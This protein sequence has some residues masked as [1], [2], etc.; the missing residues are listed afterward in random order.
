M[1]GQRIS[2]FSLI[3]LVVVLT[4]FS[5]MIAMGAPLL[6]EWQAN[7]KVRS[8]AEA[9]QNDLRQAQGEAVRRNRQVAF[10]L[11]NDAP[12]PDPTTNILP[13][14]APSNPANNWVL[15]ALPL[16]DSTE[17]K[18]EAS[19]SA[20][21][22]LSHVQ[23]SNTTTTIT[24]GVSILCFNSVGRLVYSVTTTIENAGGEKCGVLPATAAPIEFQ[25]QNARADRPLRVQVRVG[26]Q[27]RMCD[28]GRS[29][30]TQPDG[31]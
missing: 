13:V 22:I 6:A 10:V 30:A 24:G 11:T 1:L 4:I 15:L 31:C 25:I 23:S 20:G 8:V 26:G 7:G 29:I 2:G 18:D 16:R 28:P 19:R 5:I 17:A 21:F 27:I 14:F 3:E 9:L 12:T